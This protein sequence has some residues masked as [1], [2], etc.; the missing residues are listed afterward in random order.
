MRYI[1][2]VT[3]RLLAYSFKRDYMK[4]HAITTYSTPNDCT[5]Y[6]DCKRRSYCWSHTGGIRSSSLPRQKM[7]WIA[8]K[9]RMLAGTM[10][11]GVL[12]AR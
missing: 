12:D 4:K 9:R 7:S 6:S 2:H 10:R 8:R 5:L 3:M 11:V 1:F